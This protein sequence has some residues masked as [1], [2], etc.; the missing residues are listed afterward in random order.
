MRF[1][2]LLKPDEIEC[3]VAKATKR[4]VTLLLYKTARTD[5][6]LLDETVGPERWQND[7]CELDGKMYGSIGIYFPEAGWIWKK[8]CG[9]ES[10]MEAEKGQASDAFKRA[11]FKWG[12]GAELY[13]APSITIPASKCRLEDVESGRPKCYD[14]FAV[15]GIDYDSGGRIS[16][17]DIIN[18]KTGQ[19]VYYYKAG[20]QPEAAI[21][22]ER[23]GI[24][25]P[26]Y[27]DENGKSVSPQKWAARS[28]EKYGAA[29]CYDCIRAERVAR[30][31]NARATG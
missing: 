12:I 5:T 3:R 26:P 30:A 16:E 25:L 18:S 13:T 7:F 15:V 1:F 31:E 29:L 9:T 21:K 6:A 10:N 4:G 2:R 27:Q 14:K 24:E 28:K 11:G 19:S 8:D 17:L 23:C 22:C 20:A